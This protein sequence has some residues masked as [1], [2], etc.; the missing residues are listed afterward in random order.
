MGA[1]DEDPPTVGRREQPYDGTG[2]LYST[3]TWEPVG[4]P[5][6]GHTQR[7]TYVDFSADGRTLATS[8]ADGTV[9]LW[10]VGTQ[11]PIGS[12]LTLKPNT[13]PAAALSPDGS[14]LFAVSTRGPGLSF[15]TAPE[16]WKRQ[17]CAVM[18]GGLTPEQW[19]EVVPEQ[20]YISVCP[21]G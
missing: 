20:E 12:P 7:I 9:G 8:S 3:E 19:E 6:Q 21:S 15:D 18:G 13:F 14:R 5:L 17:A 2:R 10:D 11:H 1:C 4:R 16:A